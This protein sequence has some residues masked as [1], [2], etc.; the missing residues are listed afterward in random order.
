MVKNTIHLIIN[1]ASL[2]ALLVSGAFLN[3]SIAQQKVAPTAALRDLHY[4]ADNGDF[5]LKNGRLRF[6]RALYGNNKA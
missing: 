6:N 2:L 5:L 1:K 3:T 4:V